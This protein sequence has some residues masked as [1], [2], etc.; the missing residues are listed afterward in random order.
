M[1]GKKELKKLLLRFFVSNPFNGQSILY[2]KTIILDLG[3][4]KKKK[5]KHACSHTEYTNQEDNAG[6]ITNGDVPT[7]ETMPAKT[8]VLY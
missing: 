1:L 5:M 2:F 7:K 8:E 3:D 6:Y 4:L